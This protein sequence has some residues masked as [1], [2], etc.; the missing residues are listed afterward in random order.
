MS[1]DFETVISSPRSAYAE[2]QRFFAGTGTLNDALSRLAR[3][4]ERQKIDYAVIRAVALNQ[5]GFHRL[6]VDLDLLMTKED[7]EKFRETLVGIGYRPAF[8]GEKK[9]FR[10]VADNVPIE[11]VTAGEYPGDGLPKPVVFPDPIDASVDIDGVKTITLEKLVELKLASGMSASDRLK[12]LADVQEL[13]KVKGLD[14]NFVERLNKF[15][16]AKYLELFDAVE[17]GRRRQTGPE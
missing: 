4:L 16:R 2:A 7:L 5:H 15:V 9:K 11:I 10:S 1:A 12:D 8:E 14:R 13:M 3:D 6:T 17:Q